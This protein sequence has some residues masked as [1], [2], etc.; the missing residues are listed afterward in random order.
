ML[1]A[2]ASPAAPDRAGVQ[3]IETHISYV[4]LAGGFAYKI[5][6]AVDLGFLDFRALRQR[7]FYCREELRLNRRTAPEL[8]LD[9]LPLT[10]TLSRP[11]IGGA[12]PAMDWVLRMR[13]FDQ[14]GLWDRLAT[15]GQLQPAHIDAG[16]EALCALHDAA[17]VAA[18]DHPAARPQQVRA[19]VRESLAALRQACLTPHECARL[20]TLSDWEARTFEQLHDA[21]ERRARAGR[22]RECHG[23]LHLGNVTEFEG[24]TTLFDCLEFNAAL[25][26]TDVMSDVAFMAMDLHAHGL[27]RLAHRFVNGM[28]ERSG[29]H[30][31]LRVLRYF[32]LYRALVRAK[33]AA[34]RDA[35]RCSPRCPAVRGAAR[36]APLP[37]GGT[38]RHPIDGARADT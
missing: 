16:T 37:R 8:Y 31:G 22:V 20:D 17:A 34:L 10:G 4:L 25:R 21:F 2:Q 14:D 19:P 33:V 5:K 18:P 35:Q 13:A 38:C 28:V 23:D 1:Q 36:H 6:K 12:G 11:C 32:A 24:R 27:P 15:R 3:L 9:V 7:E 29:D 26:W 30:D